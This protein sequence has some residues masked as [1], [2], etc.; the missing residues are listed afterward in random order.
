MATVEFPVQGG[1]SVLVRV[2][3]GLSAGVVT[4]G[5]TVTEAMEKAD[6]SFG[7]ALGT[8]QAVANGVLEQ[9]GRMARCPEEVHLEFGLEFSASAGTALLVSGKGSAHLQVEM[10]WTAARESAA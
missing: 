10:T 2:E 8:I 3:D 9:L 4:R 6:Q 5:T 1:G 7:K